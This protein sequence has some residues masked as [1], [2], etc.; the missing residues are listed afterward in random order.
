MTDRTLIQTETTAL[1][2]APVNSGVLQRSA[3]SN[4]PVNGDLSI[5]GDVLR[6]SG[7]AFHPASRAFMAPRFGQDFNQIPVHSK[8]PPRLQKK[9]AVNAPGDIYEQEADAAAEKI[10]NQTVPHIQQQTE[11]GNPVQRKATGDAEGQ[12]APPIVDEVL[13]SPGRPLDS[14][15]QAFMEP[16]FRHDFS[17]VRVH[18][19]T[20]AEQ[21]ARDVN[22][23]AYTVGHDIVFAA[24]R[25]ATANS[26]GPRLLAHEL[27]HVVQQG[28]GGSVLQRDVRGPKATATPADWKDK[29]AKAT[30]PAD[31]AALIQSVVAPVKVVDKSADAA[32]DSAVDPNHCIKWDD[33]NPT[34]SYDDD[35]NSK[36]GR[37]ANA[38]FTKEITSGPSTAQK[39]D[40]Y[41]VLGLKA[42]DTSDVT[43]TTRILN[44]EFDHV[45]ETRGG[46]KLKGD[47]SEIAAWTT[48]FVREFHRSYSIRDRSN[49]V[50]SYIDPGFA[51]FTSLGGYYARS[52]DAT[53]KSAAVKKIADYYTATIKPHAV[54]DKVFRYWIYRGINA[55]NIA[56]LCNDV[57][58]KLGKIV[59]PAKDVKDYW[60]L[61]TATV[62]AAKFTGPPAVA[63]P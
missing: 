62:K 52:T 31:R 39:T 5:G 50:T 26:E 18:T 20:A 14:D 63:V 45:R 8:T 46:S 61:S 55:L 24:G 47:E 42:L 57:N 7:Q 10:I 3:V 48:T 16:R 12:T 2:F 60:E 34:V 30:S 22:A 41:I 35:L 32:A 54:H 1:T 11:Q 33:A 37:A 19:G 28:D 38:G 59:D 43:T 29:V 9:L 58:D 36:K 40:F 25:F 4:R 15:T 49:G 51:T 53:V 17:R 23:N 6:L 56:A 21:S 44:H 27:T 13:R